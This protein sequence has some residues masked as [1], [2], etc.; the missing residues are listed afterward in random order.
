MLV[1]GVVS[2]VTGSAAELFVRRDDAETV[3]D[4]WRKDAPEHA[5]VL[6]VEEIELE[7]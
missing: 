5:D 7:A 1:Y 4:A 2:R 3:V 6:R